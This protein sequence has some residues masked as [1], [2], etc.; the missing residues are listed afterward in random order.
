MSKKFVHLGLVVFLIAALVAGGCAQKKEAAKKEEGPKKGGILTFYI[1]NPA[2][3]DPYNAQESEGVQVV[4][5]VFDSLVDFDPLTSKLVPAVAESWEANADFTVW[6]F[7][8]RKGTKFHN[9][10][11]V[12]AEDFVYAWNRIAS[13]KTDPPSDVSYHLMPVKGFDEVQEGKAETMSGLRAVD[14]YTLEVT[15][16]Y[17]FPDFVYVVGHPALAPVPKEEVE[18]DPKAFALKPIGNGPF[19]MA[20]PWK[21]DQYIKLKRFDDYY[22][23]KPYLDGVEFKI[24]KDEQT[25]F[26]EFQAGKLDFSDN[27]PAGQIKA[28]ID[29][30]GE[31]KDGYTAEPG[32]QVLLGIEMA[33]YYLNLNNQNQY[34][35]NPK[36]RAAISLAINREAIAKTIYEGARK[37]AT[38][39]I[40]P[41]TVGFLPDQ[42][43][44]SR[45]DLEEA[46]K[47]LAEAGYPNGKGLPEFELTFNTGAGHEDVMQAVQANLKD[48][49]I[50]VKL[51]GMEWAQFIDYRQNGKHQIARDGWIM[52]YPIMDNM[53]YPLFYSKNIGMDNTSRYSNPEVDKLLDQA[54]KEADENKRIE[55]YQQIERLILD[56]AAVVPVVFYAHRAVAQKWVRGLVYSPMGLVHLEKVWLSK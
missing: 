7:K 5:N 55:L 52:D 54:R 47:L 38:G 23:E 28:S 26:L 22:G 13:P 41:G 43:K 6:T 1:S 31:S 33:T 53:L 30:W 9:G 34:L 25:A 24:F 40:P 44:Y 46:K 48:I 10:R 16:K 29:K 45:Y 21:A 11:E 37:P 56:D 32:K 42:G 2:F 20:E 18:K 50:N 51:K 49:G 12:K 39:L 27:I 14:D 4:S 3:I 15:L 35:K 8:L 17:G 36:L 19:M